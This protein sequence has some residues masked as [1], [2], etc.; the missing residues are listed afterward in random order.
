MLAVR[1]VAISVISAFF[2]S[3]IPAGSAELGANAETRNAPDKM[4]EA[5][6]DAVRE[7]A[8][9]VEKELRRRARDPESSDVIIADSGKILKRED[10]KWILPKKDLSDQSEISIVF[11]G[12]I[13][14]DTWQNPWSSI[15]YSDGIR[16]CF[17]DETWETLTGADFLVVNNEFP[18]TDR[19]TPTPGKT[20]TFRCEPWT[21]EWL[22]EMGT[23]IAALANNHVYDYGED[24]AM[25]TFD[26]LD[27]V[28]IPYIGAGRNIE[29]AEQTAYCIVNGVTVAILNATEIERYENP[30]TREAGED[31]PGVF[32]ML[33]TDRLCEKIEEA[34]EKAD[35][36]IVYAHWGTEKM[37]AADWSQTTKAQ[38]LADAGADLIVGSHPHVL[39]NIE[40]ADGV[41]VFYSLGNYFFGAAARDTGVLRVTINTQDPAISSLQFIPM[42]Q[43]SGVSTVEG[44]EKERVLD[45]MRSVS[46][47]VEIDGDG[48]FSEE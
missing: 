16:A 45:E 8:E 38:E 39:Q 31:N 20:F 7:Q 33:D 48:Y 24:G 35:L 18:Y 30:D 36:C 42:L 19:G 25:D 9:I 26:T 17:D 6:A 5:A 34:K 21:A 29:D 4:M 1:K 46:P 14:F 40:Y 15:A 43:Y 11:V 27:G 23:D 2:L 37:P 3:L 32:R 47:G 44:S 12:D 22:A 13:I 28:D 10:G 41:P